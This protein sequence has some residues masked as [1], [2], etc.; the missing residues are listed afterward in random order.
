MLIELSTIAVISSGEN[1][2]WLGATLRHTTRALAMLQW[3]E[4]GGGGHNRRV[5]GNQAG[6]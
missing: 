6:L 4:C 2:T 3:P 5:A 1:V